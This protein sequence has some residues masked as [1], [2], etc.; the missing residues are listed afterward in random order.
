[1]KNIFK[2][3][4]I[5]LLVLLTGCEA[6][7]ELAKQDK[8]IVK[9]FSMKSITAR[10]NA[11]LCQAVSGIRKMKPN[12]VTTDS[13]NSKLVFDEKTGLYFDD[14]KGLYIEKDNLKSYTFP[15]IR[16]SS[17]EKVKNICFNEKQNG[18]YD[19]FLVK[20]DLTKEEAVTLTEEQKQLR[21]KQFVTLMKDGVA[22]DKIGL[23][24][25]NIVL[26]TTTEY[27]VP[28][29]QGELTGN[30]GYTTVSHTTSVIIGSAC[31]FDFGNTGGP[32][33]N[34]G[35]GTNGNNNSSGATGSN[36]SNTGTNNDIITGINTLD[37]DDPLTDGD[38]FYYNYTD[39]M[40]HLNPDQKK[41]FGNHP[42]L[43]NYLV[44]NH[45]STDSRSFIMQMI[46]TLESDD[47]TQEQKDTIS[48]LIST[49]AE[50]EVELQTN[51]AN[52]NSINFESINDLNTY[53]QSLRTENIVEGPNN[54]SII[55]QNQV[56]A[57]KTI[58]LTPLINLA[59]EVVFNTTPSFSLESSGCKSFISNVI[60]GNSWV[61]NS[62]S[63]TNQNLTAT[64]AQ[65][66][67]VGYVLVGIKI[68]ELDFGIKQRKKIKF[69]INR[70]TGYICCTVVEN[71]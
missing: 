51:T 28:N 69:S 23:N 3:A 39:F 68:K 25:V 6:E 44:S 33:F 67:L 42:E 22:V 40:S 29:D 53:I 61:Q 55:N 60:I 9:P 24:C 70:T 54:S 52:G 45:W 5:S 21:E 59:I 27:V 12:T 16:T 38:I 14:E 18:N 62:M 26:T 56:F 30:F 50:N 19:V 4:F 34:N 47:Y 13:G 2:L 71:I 32:G 15:V 20:Y 66:T 57:T 8:I 58:E 41:L 31:Y 35:L 64:D 65:I 63:I 37:F 48:Q 49:C 36:T 11:K 17:D 43:I 10:S 46:F 1:M 7:K